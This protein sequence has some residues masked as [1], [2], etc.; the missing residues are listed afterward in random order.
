MKKLIFI[1][2]LFFIFIIHKNSFALPGDTLSIGL[3]RFMPAK[4]FKPIADFIGQKL[5]VFVLYENFNSLLELSSK[6]SEY[7]LIYTNAFGYAYAQ[8][9]DLPFKAYLVR[10]DKNGQ[11]LTY[12]SCL[13]SNKGSNITSTRDIKELSKDLEVSFT[14]ASSTSGHI[15]PRIYLTQLV[16]ESLEGGFKKLNF[17]SGHREVI[18]KVNEGKIKLGACSCQ[19]IKEEIQA[20]AKLTKTINVLWESIPIPHAVWATNNLSDPKIYE[21]LGQSLNAL[22]NETQLR[23]I[24]DLPYLTQYSTPAQDGFN[25]LINQLK[26]DDELEFYLY[27]YESFSE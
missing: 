4:K 12:K 14:Y 22:L 13:I 24:V 8:V 3:D 21:K 20:N 19:T 2:L 10:A 26:K 18:E 9:T 27:Y 25:Y 7:D 5:D 15:I 17:E 6:Q 23:E 1:C 16:G 11:T